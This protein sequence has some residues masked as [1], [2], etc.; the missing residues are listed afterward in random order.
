MADA[1]IRHQDPGPIAKLQHTSIGQPLK[2]Q[3]AVSPLPVSLFLLSLT[4][5][6]CRWLT[7]DVINARTVRVSQSIASV[8]PAVI[9]RS[10]G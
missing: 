4:I 8:V 3:V 9:C 2:H 1:A 10:R 7:S 5:G 6:L